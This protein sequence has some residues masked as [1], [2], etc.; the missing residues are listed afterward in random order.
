MKTIFSYLILASVCLA[1]RNPLQAQSNIDLS[2]KQ[3]L[4]ITL[5]GLGFT[6]IAYT[7]S[8]Y[9]DLPNDTNQRALF[10]SIGTGM[11]VTGILIL[12]SGP[13]R[14]SSQKLWTGIDM[15]KVYASSSATHN[16]YCKK[17]FELISLN[18]KK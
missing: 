17:Q 18:P 10:Y 15:S 8:G 16:S 4:G 9:N 2:D 11:A 12:T 3:V 6:T 1:G 14:R 5:F 13:K 7:Y